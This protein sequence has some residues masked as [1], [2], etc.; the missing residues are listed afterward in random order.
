[1]RRW[2]MAIVGAAMACATT[3]TTHGGSPRGVRPECARVRDDD[4][5]LRLLTQAVDERRA[6]TLRDGDE[7]HTGDRVHLRVCVSRRAWVRLFQ[8]NAAG[9]VEVLYPADRRGE[10]TEPGLVE[11]APT[12]GSLRLDPPEGNETLLLVASDRPLGERDPALA[13]AVLALRAE[14]QVSATVPGPDGGATTTARPTSPTAT[15]RR[16]ESRPPPA[17]R[18]TP[19]TAS[20]AAPTPPRSS[21]YDR[22]APFHPRGAA[23]RFTVV[24]AM[25]EG[26]ELEEL[27]ARTDD[28]VIVWRLTLVHTR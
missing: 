6:R 27:N 3:Q 21:E 16:D 11:R 8:V 13:A 24:P 26:P 2:A 7:V 23:R 19:P 20:D 5:P 1:M 15:R 9:G 14:V 10:E 17:A 25:G 4:G 28:P 12:G 18:V 22:L